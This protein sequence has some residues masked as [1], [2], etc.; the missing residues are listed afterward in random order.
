M[1]KPI[2]PFS[3]FQSRVGVVL[4]DIRLKDRFEFENTELEKRQVTVH[5]RFSE[6]YKIDAG[7][8]ANASWLRAILWAF[9]F[10]MREEAIEDLGGCAFPLMVLGRSSTYI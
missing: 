9:V 8:V 1:Q 7:L 5:G 2:A 6:D 10:A 4:N 3:R